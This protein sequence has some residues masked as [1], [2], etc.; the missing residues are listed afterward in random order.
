MT[1]EWVEWHKGYEG[2]QPLARRLLAVQQLLARA[3]D[4]RPAGLIRV[5]SMCAGDGRDLLG[6]LPSHPRRADVVA[7]LVELE[8]ALIAAGR[9]RAA[10]EG[11]NHVEFLQGDA[12]ST[13]VYAGAVPA[14]ILLVCGVFGNVTDSDIRTTIEHLPELSAAGASVFWTRGRFEPDLTPAI[15]A[16][17]SAAGYS[18]DAFVPIEG[19]TAS[20]GA[21]RLVAAPRRF[22]PGVR[23]FTF[24]PRG[25][26]PSQ[27]GMA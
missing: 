25:E 11:L 24:L 26:R 10:R 17:F 1:S 7:R 2:D 18:E 27:R 9:D 15:R 4:E 16:W 12:G 23:L 6:V 22:E 13:T 20:V 21:T 19:S 14:D 8:P 3:L 5:L